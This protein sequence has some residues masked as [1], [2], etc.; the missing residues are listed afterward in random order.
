MIGAMRTITF[1]LTV[2]LSVDFSPAELER[3]RDHTAPRQASENPL[4]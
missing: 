1:H 2:R 4:L 3:E